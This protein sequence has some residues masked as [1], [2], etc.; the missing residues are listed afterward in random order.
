MKTVFKR[1]IDSSGF[2]SAPIG[3]DALTG[4]PLLVTRRGGQTIVYSVGLNLKDEG[5]VDAGT[6]QSGDEDDIV[7][8]LPK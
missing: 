1:T 6:P 4:Q 5:G 2:E 7:W 8:R 3:W